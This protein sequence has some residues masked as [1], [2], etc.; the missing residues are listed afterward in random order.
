MFTNFQTNEL[1]TSDQIVKIKSDDE[2]E[3]E[4]DCRTL[5]DK[6]VSMEDENIETVV[7]KTLEKNIAQVNLKLKNNTFRKFTI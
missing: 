6:K 2:S 3:D 1:Q 7:V 5:T 4:S